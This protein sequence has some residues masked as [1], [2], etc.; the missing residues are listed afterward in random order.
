MLVADDSKMK[1]TNSSGLIFLKSFFFSS[2][3]SYFASFTLKHTSAKELFLSFVLLDIRSRSFE[4]TQV[5]N[6]AFY[7]CAL[8]LALSPFLQLWSACTA[9]AYPLSAL[10]IK[11]YP[12]RPI[13]CYLMIAISAWQPQP[14]LDKR[15]GDK[16][17]CARACNRANRDCSGLFHCLVSWNPAFL[18]NR[19]RDGNWWN[20]THY[21][22][23]NV[24]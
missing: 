22:Q 15:K 23:L 12:N 1:M 16:S 24:R 8:S 10:G 18:A 4:R 13:G 17:P 9:S 6:R 19:I 7:A 21:V 20:G 5:S 14:S 2:K 11:R 3:E